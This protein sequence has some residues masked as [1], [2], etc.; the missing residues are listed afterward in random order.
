MPHCPPRIWAVHNH[1]PAGYYSQSAGDSATSGFSKACL[2]VL[3]GENRGLKQKGGRLEA[4]RLS[5]HA[6]SGKTEERTRSLPLSRYVDHAEAAWYPEGK[7]LSAGIL[8]TYITE[9][10]LFLQNSHV[11]QNLLHDFRTRRNEKK[12]VL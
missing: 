11:S 3:G 8:R 9:I 10:F 2:V 7:S 4:P 1:S 6:F 12:D 5:F